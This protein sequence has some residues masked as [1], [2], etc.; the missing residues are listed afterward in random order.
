MF[1]INQRSEAEVRSAQDLTP[2]PA[3][4]AS[5]RSQQQCEQQCRQQ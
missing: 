2:Q 3:A 5:H 1:M 4:A